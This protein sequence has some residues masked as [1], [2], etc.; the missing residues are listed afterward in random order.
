M[1]IKTILTLSFLISFINADAHLSK[2]ELISV[3]KGEKILNIMCDKEKIKS[4]NST[5]AK[6]L[7]QEIKKN[8]LCKNINQ[9]KLDDVLTFLTLKKTQTLIKIDAPKKSKCPVC[10]MFVAKFP[11]WE[12]MI[13]TQNNQKYYFDGVKDLMKFYF[14]PKRFHQK[15]EKIK[16]I[17]V[18][19]FYTLNPIKAKNA[20]YV[21][22]AN[23]YGPMGNEFIP[24]KTEKDA[25]SFKKEHL[26]KSILT[27]DK[28]TE[29]LVYSLDQ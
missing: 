27:F 15:D 20:H 25:Q 24:F 21:I 11:K 12:S 22:G 7:N 1:L 5:D 8:N 28:I 17:L 29:E 6:Y 2:K 16:E 13:V 9:K 18:L 19:D 26:G 14:D 3:K 23:I 4:L 10:G